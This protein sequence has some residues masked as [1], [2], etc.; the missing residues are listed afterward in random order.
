MRILLRPL[1]LLYWIW[2]V[3]LFLAL[4]I[5]VFVWAL[6]VV[7]FGPVRGGNLIYRACVLWGAIWFPL[8]GVRHRNIEEAPTDPDAAFIYVSNHVSYF[9]IP[10]IVKSFRHPVRPLGKAEIAKVPI[11]GFIYRNAI[12]TVDRSSPENRA[13]SVKLLR[14]TIEKGV[15]VLVFP[16]GTFNETGQPLKDFYDGAF[17][18]AIETGTPIQPVLMLDT[19]SRMHPRSIFSLR[20]GR[21]RTVFL[22][23]IPVAGYGLADVARLRKEVYRRM[24]EGLLRWKAPWIEPVGAAV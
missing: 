20:P 19:W 10:V 4:M 22:E 15:S 18:I 2:A 23:P 7:G 12:V 9:D 14:K 11:F 1:H 5:P 16:E 17:R 8:I 21:S 13:R 24:E 6:L 3:G